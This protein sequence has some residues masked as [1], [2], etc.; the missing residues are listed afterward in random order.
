MIDSSGI[1]KTEDLLHSW[2]VSGICCFAL[3]CIYVLLPL[4]DFV[5]AYGLKHGNMAKIQKAPRPSKK[6]PV[7]QCQAFK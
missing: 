1:S 7:S 2:G 4:E 5:V 6:I 3:F